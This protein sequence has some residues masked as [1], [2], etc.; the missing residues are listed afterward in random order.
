MFEN[1]RFLNFKGYKWLIYAAAS[2]AA[3][4]H[5]GCAHRTSNQEDAK[6]ETIVSK[7]LSGD[8]YNRKAVYLHQ[9]QSPQRADSGSSPYFCAYLIATSQVK[10][11]TPYN[12]VKNAFLERTGEAIS[13]DNTKP[14]TKAT[15][16]VFPL[17]IDPRLKYHYG[18]NE[19]MLA[20]GISEAQNAAKR[21]EIGTAFRLVSKTLQLVFGV[22][23]ALFRIVT[24]KNNSFESTQAV[25]NLSRTATEITEL[26]KT[27]ALDS[28]LN[29]GEEK[30]KGEMSSKTVE[31]IGRQVGTDMAVFDAIVLGISSIKE[32]E[33]T[34]GRALCPENFSDLLVAFNNFDSSCK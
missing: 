15:Y 19:A 21:A 9:I 25:D 3:L 30:L 10:L 33:A 26:K 22:P 20:Q 32:T 14:N 34:K 28:L 7:S 13:L 16:Q 5:F 6:Q 2:S 18:F 8:R 29:E 24:H 12:L 1:R 31:R 27:C 23:T 11:E 4:T 17:N